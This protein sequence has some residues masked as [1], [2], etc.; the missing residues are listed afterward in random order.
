MEESKKKERKKKERKKRR[1]D[2]DTSKIRQGKSIE[3]GRKGMEE[4]KK[5]ETG[6]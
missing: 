3:R 2:G 4:S 1:K 5:R 6:R